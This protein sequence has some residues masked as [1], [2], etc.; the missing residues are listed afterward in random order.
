M[1]NLFWYKILFITE[2][3]AAEILFTTKLRR[4]RY[5]ALRLLGSLAMLYAVAIFYPVGTYVANSWWYSS[6]MFF[7]MF[8]FGCGTLA[9]MYKISFSGALFFALTA[10]TLQHICHELYT[11]IIAVTGLDG[12]IDMYS[13]SVLDFSNFSKGTLVCVLIYVDIY[14]LGYGAARLSVGRIFDHES[15]K[16]KSVT[17]LW[18]G[19]FILLIDVVLSSVVIYSDG[20][21]LRYEII[22]CVYNI[23]CCILVFYI[24]INLVSITDMR[25]ETAQM[26]EMLRQSQRQYMLQK[27]TIN[28]INTK[29]HDLRHRMSSLAQHGTVG[30]EEL[31]EISDAILIYDAK[32][33][34]GNE[35]LDVILTEKSLI[36][37]E[38][39]IKMTCLADGSGL[40]FIREGDLYALF[41]NIA[42]NAIEAASSLEDAEKRCISLNVGTSGAFVSVSENNY[43][44]GS[45]KFADDGLPVTEKDT[46]YHGY[47]MLSIDTVVKKYEGDLS[48]SVKGDMFRLNVLIPVPR[49]YVAKENKPRE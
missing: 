23:V 27:E 36:C 15:I 34:T 26:K 8:A 16:L 46:D 44:K 37:R 33:N 32:V 9:F 25:T 2:L 28:L 6:L 40:G 30:N 12:G 1:S 22:T 45:I 11:L 49:E 41:G 18:F 39:G 4:R 3:I 10:Y 13:T 17:L 24:Q 20:S 19:A 43:Y 31:Q 21:D 42:D 14:I 48:V 29:C 38:K 47:G 5:F 35:A 7:V